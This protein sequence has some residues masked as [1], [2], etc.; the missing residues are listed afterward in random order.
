[1]AILWAHF[2]LQMC[3]LY[4]EGQDWVHYSAYFLC[5]LESNHF[6]HIPAT[7]LTQCAIRLH[8]WEEAGLTYVQF[9]VHWDSQALLSKPAPRLTSPQSSYCRS[10]ALVILLARPWHHGLDK[11]A[12]T[13]RANIEVGYIHCLWETEMVRVMTQTIGHWQ[14][15]QSA[16]L[17]FA[18]PSWRRKRAGCVV[19]KALMCM[20]AAWV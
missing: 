5:L 7:F 20:R 14:K 9:A 12:F 11:D 10:L 8:S 4:W 16:L 13:H 6:L 19:V 3:F 18:P 2:S 1:M 15:H 17:R